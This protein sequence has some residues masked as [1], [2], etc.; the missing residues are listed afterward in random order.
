MSL[1][2]K[3]DERHFV[4][5]LAETEDELRAAQR[6]RYR[7]F[8]EEL[9]ASGPTVDHDRQLETDDFDAIYDHL[10]LIDNRC[11]HDAPERVAGVYRLLHSDVARANGG[12]YSASEFDLSVLERS[13]RVLLE[14]GRSCV[15]REYRGGMAMYL[16]WN[17]LADYV[18][19]HKV[20]VMFGV[21]SYHGCD[22]GA[23][24]QSLSFLHQNH[25]AP[26]DSRVRARTPNR[27]EMALIPPR[28]IEQKLAMSQTPALIN[29]YL[30]LGGC[31]GDGAFIDYNFNTIDVCLMMDTERMS[32]RHKQAYTRRSEARS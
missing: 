31:V 22:A 28:Q 17:A 1:N 16:L 14:L 9:G 4:V 32:L 5:K 6:L 18:I 8:V 13:E 2:L 30:R 25:L 29:A 7:V 11:D 3:S 26:P 27:Q 19:G 10:L 24:A 23:I 12:F 15:G 20:E 21:A